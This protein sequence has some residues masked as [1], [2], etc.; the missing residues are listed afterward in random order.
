MSEMAPILL[1][2]AP[3]VKTVLVVVLLLAA[4]IHMI[5]LVPPIR[6]RGDA[7]AD[8][9]EL[10]QMLGRT[11]RALTPMRPVGTC[12]FDG[13]RVECVAESGYVESDKLITVIRVEGTQLTVRV[14]DEA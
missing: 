10:G 4:L 7:I 8:A 2:V 5:R 12:D 14:T 6:R 11:G 3:W 9:D 1:Q 13:H